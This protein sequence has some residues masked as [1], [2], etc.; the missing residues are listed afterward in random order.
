MGRRR[1]GRSA[2]ELRSALGAGRGRGAAAL[3]RR[4]AIHAALVDAA[5]GEHGA[6][7]VETMLLEVRPDH[8]ATSSCKLSLD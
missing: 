8:N 7:S 4:A 1:G 3:S 2:A 5:L 6:K